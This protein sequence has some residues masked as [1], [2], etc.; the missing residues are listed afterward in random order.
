MWELMWGVV[1]GEEH[2]ICPYLWISLDPSLW[3]IGRNLM[4]GQLQSG[5]SA[6]GGC[7][8]SSFP[9]QSVQCSA[10]SGQL[11]RAYCR[12]WW[13]QAECSASNSLSCFGVKLHKLTKDQKCKERA[14]QETY[15]FCIFLS[16][17]PQLVW[18]LTTAF[19]CLH[20]ARVLSV[21]QET[22]CLLNQP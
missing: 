11:P 18:G 16:F 20:G 13:H 6:A 1:L 19:C 15:W 21:P 8:G 10:I 3:F 2:W 7:S 14:F 12:D 9:T 22:L 17:L 5:S 4:G